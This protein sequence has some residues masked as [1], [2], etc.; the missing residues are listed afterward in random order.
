WVCVF[1]IVYPYAIYPAVLVS[2]NRI[3]KRR[4][5]AADPEYV[6]TVSIVLPVHNEAARVVAKVR[7]ILSLDYPF[8]KLQILVVGDGCTDDSLQKA[9]DEGG[10]LVT[11][12]PLAERAGKAAAL[13]AG[14][15]QATGEIVVF[16]DAGI[17]LEPK[18]LRSLIAHFA[19]PA[20][21]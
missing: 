2:L 11:V 10:E 20:V 9:N 4:V 18:S 7:N 3:C 19:D 6:P 12:I 16:T 8:E 13:N 17:I 1:L 15:A 5:H 21:G 14:L